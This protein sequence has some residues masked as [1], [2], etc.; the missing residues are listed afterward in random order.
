VNF[1]WR[2]F[3]AISVGF[4][5]LA[6]CGQVLKLSKKNNSIASATSAP[7]LTPDGVVF[8]NPNATV[9][10]TEYISPS[11]SHCAKFDSETYPAFKAK[12]IDT[13]LVRFQIHEF[14]TPP[15][16]Y[17]S[18]A[19][20]LA[21]CAGPTKYM[22]VVE[23]ALR[24]QKEMFATQ[25]IR[26]P[27]LS[28]AQSAGMGEAEFNICLSDRHRLSDIYDSANRAV[29]SDHVD[30]TPSFSINGKIM[31]GEQSLDEFAGAI[32]PIFARNALAC[33][34]PKRA[35][36]VKSQKKFTGN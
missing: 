18:G 36:D 12:Y 4:C 7:A 10:V 2:K 20:A 3:T 19:F 14:L 31:D 5:F 17:A 28:V 29:S 35:D 16:E 30:G 6:S 8:G 1:S 26:G 24:E 34:N 15:D 21:R 11:C 23:A 25:D 27:L 9:T 13:G 22:D 33:H 32:D